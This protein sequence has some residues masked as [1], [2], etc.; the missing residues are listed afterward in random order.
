MCFLSARLFALNLIGLNVVLVAEN[1]GVSAY[2]L[3]LFLLTI[4]WSKQWENATACPYSPVEE[5][6]Q[7]TQYLTTAVLL[8]IS[9]VLGGIVIFRY[10]Q[11]FWA[12]ELVETHKGRAFEECTADLQVIKLY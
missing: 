1:Y 10:V 2:A 9:Q 6:L 3:Y 12:L 11:L 5:I 8:I 7:G 4:W